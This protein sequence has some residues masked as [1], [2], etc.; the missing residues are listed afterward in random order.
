MPMVR[1]LAEQMRRLTKP[2][3]IYVG[4]QEFER[5]LIVLGGRYDLQLADTVETVE[6]TLPGAEEI[7]ASMRGEIIKELRM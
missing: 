6:R 1:E 7:R 4:L 3:E 2:E 5:K